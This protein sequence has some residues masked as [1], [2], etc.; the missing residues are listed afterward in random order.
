MDR[1]KT[2]IV[3]TAAVAV[4][5]LVLSA[6]AAL[7][8]L[9]TVFGVA[10]IIAP[11]YIWS[12]V[13]LRSRIAGLE[14]LIVTAGLALLGPIL[15]GL[16]LYTSGILLNRMAWV[17]LLAGVTVVGDAVLLV[18][19]L[20]ENLH[21]PKTRQDIRRIPARQ[22]MI[23]GVAVLI[24][25]GAVG[26]ARAGAAIQSSPGFTA[27]S[28]SPVSKQPS[29]AIVGVTNHQG[30]AARYRLVLFHNGRTSAS[31]DLTLANGQT[32]QHEINV[33]NKSNF[34]ADLYRAPDLKHPFRQVNLYSNGSS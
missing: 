14:R 34:A 3:I 15:G 26:V 22:A 30:D 33:A 21:T 12:Q 5:S 2:T 20:P 10:L 8:P 31:W 18:R 11:A 19:G 6:V 25:A 24:A 9:M 23:F 1:S 27:L 28:L 7:R 4:F 13:L 17:G 16:A 29:L 32:W